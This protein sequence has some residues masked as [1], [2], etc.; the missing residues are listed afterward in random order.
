LTLRENRRRIAPVG[1]K[2]AT[3]AE[4]DELDELLEV[5]AREIPNLEPVTEGI[6]ERIQILAKAFDRSMEETLVES[7]LD[8]RAFGVL[9]KLRAVGP[10]YR[11]SAGQLAS[12]MRLSSGAMTNRLDRVEAAGLI[13]R[14]PDPHDRRGTLVEPTEAGHA[15]WDRTVGTQAIREAKIA[16]VL[17]EADRVALHDLLRALMRA[18]PRESHFVGGE[19]PESETD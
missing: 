19:V 12:H 14:L 1:A 11:R 5:W 2:A 7:G 4:R 8:R 9:G 17:D 15:I 13:R 3:V 16:A 10:P 6:V 18:F